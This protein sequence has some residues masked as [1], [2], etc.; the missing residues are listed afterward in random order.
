MDEVSDNGIILYINADLPKGELVI[1]VPIAEDEVF[2]REAAFMI[3]SDIRD[4]V[5]DAVGGDDD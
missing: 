1:R 5:M 3:M 4:I 2:D